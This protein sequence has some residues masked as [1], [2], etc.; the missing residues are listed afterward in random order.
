MGEAFLKFKHTDSIKFE[1]LIV[2]MR[3]DYEE[4]CW[5]IL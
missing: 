4:E 3:L 5:L 2:S 1:E